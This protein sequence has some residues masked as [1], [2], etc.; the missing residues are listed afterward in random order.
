MDTLQNGGDTLET[1][2]PAYLR[3][4]SLLTDF[5]ENSDLEDS[6][7]KQLQNIVS[8]YI[9]YYETL[10]TKMLSKERIAQR[11]IRKTSEAKTKSSLKEEF[12]KER[13][14]LIGK[15][16]EAGALIE[17]YSSKAKKAKEKAKQKQGILKQFIEDKDAEI[18]EQ[19]EKDNTPGSS[20]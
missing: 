8:L 6:K 3:L 20:K 18:V 9:S 11:F 19:K 5:I 17:K 1:K 10:S 4:Q 15:I 13:E 12:E 7:R 2:D 14:L 16:N